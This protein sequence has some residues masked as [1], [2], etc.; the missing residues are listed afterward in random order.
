LGVARKSR[1][2]PQ[3]AICLGGI[4]ATASCRTASVTGCKEALPGHRKSIVGNVSVPTANPRSIRGSTPSIGIPLVELRMGS[5][6]SSGF[7]IGAAADATIYCK[8]P[9][10]ASF[11][12]NG[13]RVREQFVAR[14]MRL[15]QCPEP[16]GPLDMPP[17]AFARWAREGARFCS[18]RASCRRPTRHT[19]LPSDTSPIGN[20][21]RCRARRCHGL[22]A[23]PRARLLLRFNERTSAIPANWRDRIAEHWKRKP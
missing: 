2:E 8:R 10:V 11:A 20:T 3:A 23:Y 16:S 7:L 13:H 1:S 21:K 15:R 12:M 4:W 22:A 9:L 19:M 18:M 5:M 6:R 17:P 14:V